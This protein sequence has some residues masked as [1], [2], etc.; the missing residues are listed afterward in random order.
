MTLTET[1]LKWV[2]GNTLDLTVPLQVVTVDENGV[3]TK[4]DYT[5]PQGSEIRVY[6]VGRLGSREY[7]PCVSGN[8]VSFTDNGSLALGTYGLEITIKEP[9]ARNLRAF[10]CCAIQIVNS[11]DELGEMYDGRV[12]LDPELFFRGDGAVGS[13]NG[14][15]GHVT[16]TA[17]DVGALPADTPI[18]SEQIQA[19]WNQADQTKKDFIKN[20]PTIPTIPQNL[21]GFNNDTNFITK[22]VN[23]LVN[24][25][26]KSE[27]F[28]KA[29]V[30]ALLNALNPGAEIPSGA[31]VDY[32]VDVEEDGLY[33]V[34]ENRNIG[35]QLTDEGFKAVGNV[36]VCDNVPRP[37]RIVM[38]EFFT[39]DTLPTQK[40]EQNPILACGRIKA[41]FDG[42]EIYKYATLEV[43][44]AS[45]ASYPK[46][47]WTFAFFNDS[48]YS[49]E[50][51]FRIGTLV[52]HSEYV[53]KANWI[54]ATHC[55]NIVS[56][57]LWEQFVMSRDGYP[58]RECEVAYDDTDTDV[59]HRID[60]GAL[61]HVEGFPCVLYIN[62]EFYG[63][64]DFNIGKKRANYNLNKSSATQVQMQAE[65]HIDFLNFEKSTTKW[66]IRNP[67]NGTFNSV[68]PIVAP[69][70]AS[71]DPTDADFKTNF[72]TTHNLQNAID[73]LIF[74]EFIYADDCV[75]K[76]FQLTT[77]DGEVFSFMPYDL[78]TTF[79]LWWDGSKYTDPSDPSVVHS[80]NNVTQSAMDFW[81]GF[82]EAYRTEIAAR[83]SELKSKGVISVDNIYNLCTELTRKY[84]KDLFQKEQTKWPTIPSNTQI[85]TS[86]PQILDWVEDRITWMD[87]HFTNS[88]S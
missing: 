22:A 49:D 37:E 76:N 67:K 18:G 74:I 57:R 24:Y 85:H 50:Y 80:T 41:N 63:I 40:N 66:E 28:S 8:M 3:K 70:F 62:G 51:E 43:Q 27:V 72:P 20:K 68:E 25:Y 59:M 54:D 34:D 46:K 16:L 38:L 86:V 9:A 60:T 48:E 53:F 4:A 10:K 87:S 44:G 79:N 5:P 69:W 7:E 31:S 33:F 14:K 84:G 21:S 39:D 75:D 17:E 13:V 1:S 12:M 88:N 45:S 23:D 83:Y 19:D 42:L 6:L 58:K 29:E 2:R 78:D 35:A 61:C 56:N 32:I 71:N 77:W 15:T 52:P 26:L 73:Y 36:S 64:G 55:R 11:S 82:L 30:T 65:Q 81:D 47:N